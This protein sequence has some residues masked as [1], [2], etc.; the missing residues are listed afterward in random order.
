MQIVFLY[1]IHIFVINGIV[2][3]TL[4]TELQNVVPT[5]KFILIGGTN[6][7]YKLDYDFTVLKDV[8]TGP[9]MDNPLCIPKKDG[10][11]FCQRGN[12]ETFL[13]DNHNKVLLFLD[14]KTLLICGTLKYGKCHLRNVDTFQHIKNQV[15]D[16]LK[17]GIASNNAT[18]STVVELLIKDGKNTLLVA[19]TITSSNSISSRALISTRNADLAGEL[20]EVANKENQI[21]LAAFLHDI[22]YPY[23]LI[24][25]KSIFHTSTFIYTTAVQDRSINATYFI[26]KLSRMKHDY[27]YYIE[28]QIMCE[29]NNIQYDVIIS[30]SVVK[31]NARNADVI[32]D[33]KS[34]DHV[35]FV[36]FARS[37]RHTKYY[38]DD[39]AVCYFS[40]KSIDIKLEENVNNCI[41]KKPLPV[42]IWLS[43]DQC[44]VSLVKSSLNVFMVSV[45]VPLVW[46]P[47]CA[48]HPTFTTL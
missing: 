34:N 7:L 17:S 35:M 5:D 33:G 27:T 8:K 42:A 10:T 9:E 19:R 2:F 46:V 26:S 37:K 21:Q 47:H 45:E 29:K 14:K 15:V 13:T 11:F 6:K 18:A 12:K 4:D 16:D 3:K 48:S 22:P 30:T 1:L 31:L 32:K 23:Y 41:N 44:S 24:D 25:Y 28:Q 36:L 39:Y 43:S 40:L 20:L 38:S